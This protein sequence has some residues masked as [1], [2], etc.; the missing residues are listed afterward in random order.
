MNKLREEDSF[1]TKNKLKL[2]K[3]KKYLKSL[4][5]VQRNPFLTRKKDIIFLSHP[6]RK[7]QSN[8]KWWDIFT[9]PIIDELNLSSVSIEDD[10][11]NR[12][13][14]PAQ[15]RNLRYFTFLDTL[16][17]LKRL[18]FFKRQQITEKEK[19]FLN[20]ISEALFQRFGHRIDVA[21]FVNGLFIRRKR[22]NPIYKKLL[23]RIKPKIVIVIV[24]YGKENF[25]E[26]CKEMNILVIELQ[27][28]VISK[29]HVGYSYEGKK[30]RKE[31]FPDYFFTFGDYWSLVV[32]F[33]VESKRII[34]TGYPFFE[35]QKKAY[36]ST[37][38]KNQILFISQ[39]TSGGETLSK[40]AAELSNLE[41]F[42]YHVVYKLHPR[43]SY[44]WK[45]LYPW[46]LECKA[47]VIDHKGKQLYQLF[48]ESKIQIGINSTALYEGLGFNLRTYILD[49]PGIEY[50]QSLLDFLEVSR[51]RC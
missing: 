36:K 22:I 10:F 5:Y 47:E 15:T 17:N 48:A 31:T 6:R 35:N 20:S 33:P 14:S 51:I 26:V 43:E 24:S 9:D 46:L 49:E 19:I 44:S 3:L 40:L 11:L 23:K 45:N 27:H 12:Y 7:L 21:G 32:N 2:I 38:K 50:M 39:P 34:S 8:G 18:L 29:Y 4:I 42:D 16:T 30:A 25:I 41:H 13:L 37:K 28:G 1:V